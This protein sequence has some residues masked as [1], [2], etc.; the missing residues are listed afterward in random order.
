M[1]ETKGLRVTDLSFT[2]SEQL[3]ER[4]LKTIP[5]GCQTFSKSYKHYPRGGSP[6]FAERGQGAYLFDVDGNRFIDMVNALAA[7]T[8]GYC[9]PHVDLAIKKQ[10][11]KG[12]IF[13]LSN[14]LEAKLSEK[15]ATL[16]PCSEMSRFGKNGS[17][18]TTAAIRLAR[19]YTDRDEVAVCGYHG[20]HDWYI[21][22][23]EK[24]RGVPTVTQALTHSFQFNNLES[25]KAVF[26]ARKGKVAAVILEPMNVAYPQDGFL[27]GVKTLCEENGA[28]LV[29]DETVTGFRFGLG[30]AQELFGVTPDLATFGK[31]IANGMPLSVVTGRAE[32]MKLLDEVFFSF[33][34][35]GEL[36]S[37]AAALAT[38]EKL[39]QSSGTQEIA[40][41]GTKLSEGI[42]KLIASHSCEDFLSVSGHPVWSFFNIH[43]EE[44]NELYL[45]KTLYM[46]ETL[47]RGLISLGSHNLT[48]SHDVSVIEQIISIYAEVIKVFAT[49]K[50][51]GSIASVLEVEPLT[52]LFGVRKKA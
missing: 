44:P 3:L 36:L 34:Y 12:I 28:V 47:K 48:L 35:G 7:V 19:A 33:T 22:S 42:T 11:E 2:C 23:T 43:V 6:F 14:E 52:P 29:F 16:I 18:A 32:I 25:L 4:A 39:E 51:E 26:E 27:S 24:K 8:L 50:R 45:W 13:S 37:I 15:L 21:G 20:W 38:I 17:D 46:Q 49:V 41:C 10:L 40:K 5:L 9:D 1:N 30:G 31:G